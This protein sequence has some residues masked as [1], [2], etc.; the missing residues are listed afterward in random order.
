MRLCSGKHRWIP[1][2][3]QTGDDARNVDQTVDSCRGKRRRLHDHSTYLVTRSVPDIRDCLV[4]SQHD[5]V[6][7]SAVPAIQMGCAGYLRHRV[8]DCAGVTADRWMGIPDAWLMAIKTMELLKVPDYD[9]TPVRGY[10]CGDGCERWT[11]TV[12]K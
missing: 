3:W 6:S 1:I 8:P 11:E 2:S 4:D 9:G 10:P 7:A 12:S 5:S